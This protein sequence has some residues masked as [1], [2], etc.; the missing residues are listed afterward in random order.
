MNAGERRAAASL[1]AIFALRMLGLF[2]VLPVFTLY[3][4]GY[5]QY[6]PALAGL[7]IGIY[8]LTQALFQIPFGMLSDRYGRKKLIIIGL[9]LFAAGSVLAALA[10]SIVWVI[11][12]RAVQGLGAISA[13]VIALAA[14]LTRD[15]QRTKTMAVIGASIGVSFGAALVVGPL[16]AERAGLAGLFWVTAGLALGGI[17]VLVCLVPTPRQSPFH[18]DAQTLPSQFRRV[19]RDADLLRLDAGI[20]L[21]HMIMT[22]TFVALPLL[23]RD[24]GGVP[25]D[26]HW[27]I[28]L[29]ML[30]CS[31]AVM[32]PV[33]LHADKHNRVKHAFLIAVAALGLAQW[34]LL[35]RHDHLGWL[36]AFLVVYMSAFNILEASLPSLVSRLAPADLKGT[37]LGV[38]STCQHFGTFCGGVLGGLVVGYLGVPAVFGGCALLALGWLTWAAGMR[39]PRVLSSYLLSLGMVDSDNVDSLTRRLLA[40]DGV[41]EVVI[42]IDEQ[43]AYLKVEKKCLDTAALRAISASRA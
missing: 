5:T 25:T 20:C 14:D 6:T 28:Y 10:D 12:G 27:Q 1:A 38:Y 18:R 3:A 29:F 21:L 23:L 16:I 19:L 15:N 37:A 43:K 9:L 39:N 13:V 24:Y 4:D 35:V 42:V 22:A 17:A 41:V 33:I 8:G 34:A 36:L 30:V 7:A 40:I 26:R 32:A 31:M 2:M 11:V